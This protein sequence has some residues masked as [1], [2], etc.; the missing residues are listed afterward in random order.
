LLV[1]LSTFNKIIIPFCRN[2]KQKIILPFAS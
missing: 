1:E 2:R